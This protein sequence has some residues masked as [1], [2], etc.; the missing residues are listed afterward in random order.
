MALEARATQEDILLS[1][2]QTVALVTAKKQKGPLTTDCY[3]FTFRAL[4][5]GVQSRHPAFPGSQDS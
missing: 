5:G 3:T 4:R 2:E 1:D